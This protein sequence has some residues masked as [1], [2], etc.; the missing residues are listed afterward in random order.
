MRGV[1]CLFYII[2][3]FFFIVFSRSI[4]RDYVKSTFS[5]F[6][7]ISQ[8]RAEFGDPYYKVDQYPPSVGEGMI[9]ER[10]YYEG[11]RV[12]VFIVLRWGLIFGCVKYES[13]SGKV[14]SVEFFA[15]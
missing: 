11:Y 1:K 15:A 5:K 9:S 4:Y 12:G 3:S 10:E 14:V 6:E 13:S 7:N 8:V 2:F